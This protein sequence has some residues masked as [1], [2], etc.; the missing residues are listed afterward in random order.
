MSF[1]I[2]RTHDYD[3]AIYYLEKALRYKPDD[4]E[5]KKKLDLLRLKVGF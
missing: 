3:D 4:S 2:F 5:T 1:C